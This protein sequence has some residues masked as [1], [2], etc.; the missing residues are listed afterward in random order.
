MTEVLLTCYNKTCCKKF[1]PNE[2]SDDACQYHPGGPIFHDALKGWSCCKKR[3]TDFSEFLSI[4]GCTFGRHNSQKPAQPQK[5][6]IEEVCDEKPSVVH[7]PIAAPEERPSV[8][9]PRKE[10]TVKLTSSYNKAKASQVVQE[11]ASDGIKIGTVCKNKSCN[12][13]YTDTIEDQSVCIHHPGAPVFH[14]GMKFWSC[15][16]RK[17]SDFN[18]FLNQDGCTRGEHVWKSIGDE[19][20]K[21]RYDWHQT[22]TFV[23]L[24]IYAKNAN[25]DQCK[26]IANPVSLIANVSF[27]GG[28]KFD[29]LLELE[30]VIDCQQSKVT[31]SATKI[32]I[33]LRKNRIGSWKKYAKALEEVKEIKNEPVVKKEEVAPTPAAAADDDEDEEMPKLISE[34]DFDDPNYSDDSLSGIEDAEFD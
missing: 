24:N 16:E 23:T 29:L 15:C 10:L 18:A 3:S 8:D 1:D 25:A 11:I 4:P 19:V 2:N 28:K 34:I 9:Q 31:I 6:I 12:A 27:E 30:G 17:T 33:M 32:E 5:P 21:C 13:T 14:E 20:V 7:K 22:A 26:F